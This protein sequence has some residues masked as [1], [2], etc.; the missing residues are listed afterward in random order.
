MN[1]VFFNL[2]MLR[3][4]IKGRYHKKLKEIAEI[5]RDLPRNQRRKEFG[6]TASGSPVVDLGDR[7]GRE[8]WWKSR[9][10]DEGKV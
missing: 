9:V 7:L 1:L 8:I 10:F 6:F 5:G 2:D 3:T 4:E